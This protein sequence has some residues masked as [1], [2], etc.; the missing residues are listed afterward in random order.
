MARKDIDAVMIAIPDTWHAWSPSKRSSTTRDVYGEKPLARTIA[1]Q[2]AIV[3][4]VE[5]YNASGRPAR[6]R[7]SVEKLPLRRR[8]RPQRLHRQDQPVEVGLPSAITDFAGTGGP[9]LKRLASIPGAPKNLA[10]V[11]PGTAAWDAA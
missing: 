9:L 1:E 7:R 8:D 2:Q 6:G 10:Q 5:K 11:V 4:A 3:K